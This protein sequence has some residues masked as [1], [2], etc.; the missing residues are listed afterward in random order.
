M[1][2]PD[3]VNTSACIINALAYIVNAS[4]C[5][6]NALAYIVNASACIINALAYIVNTSACIVN[7]LACIVN[8]LACI[9]NAT[10]LHKAVLSP[11]LLTSDKFCGGVKIPIAK[12]NYELRKAFSIASFN[13]DRA[14]AS[15]N[16]FRLNPIISLLVWGK[17]K[18]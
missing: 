12:L 3:N 2:I 7:A 8:A 16:T 18:G 5:I 15:I 14:G 10:L 11:L 17:V 13:A 4:A 9:K 1:A 6:I